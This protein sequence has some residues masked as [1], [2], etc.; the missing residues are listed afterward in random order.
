MRLL[1]ER[2]A[3]HDHEPHAAAEQGADLVEDDPDKI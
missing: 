2:R 3:A 1:G